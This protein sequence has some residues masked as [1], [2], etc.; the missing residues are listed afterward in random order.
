M[1]WHIVLTQHAL[2]ICFTLTCAIETPT[3]QQYTKIT[4]GTEKEAK[5]ATWDLNLT[6][7]WCQEMEQ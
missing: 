7:L 3:F 2:S 6:G 4:D 5:N 1:F